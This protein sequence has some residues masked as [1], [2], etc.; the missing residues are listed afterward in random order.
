[1]TMQH[2]CGY[3]TLA[4]SLV[5]CGKTVRQEPAKSLNYFMTNVDDAKKTAQNCLAFERND[6]STMSP[7][8][9]QAWRET[10]A[11]INCENAKHAYGLEIMAARQRELLKN[12][13]R[14][15]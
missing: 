14:Y 6:L 1:M 3:L 12:D 13:E 2:L 9:Q 5:G 11:G 15:K 4:L 8:Q 7:T 10:T